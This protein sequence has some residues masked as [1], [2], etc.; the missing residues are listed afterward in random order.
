[1]GG[2]PEAARPIFMEAEAKFKAFQNEDPLW[3]HWGEEANR[4]ELEKLQ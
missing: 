3:P 2:G 1:M 4:A